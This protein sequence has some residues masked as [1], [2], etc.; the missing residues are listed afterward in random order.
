VFAIYG[1]QNAARLAFYGLY[2]LQHRGQQSAG[3]VT[4]GQGDGFAFKKGMGLVSEVFHEDDFSRLPGHIAC[5]HVGYASAGSYRDIQP[6]SIRYNDQFFTLTMTGG[7]LN[8]P[9]LRRRLEKEGSIFQTDSDSE[10]IMHLLARHMHQGL[11]QGLISALNLL[12]GAYCLLLMTNDSL[13]AARDP[14]GFRPLCLGRMEDAYILASETCAL[15]LMDAVY[16]REVEPGEILFVNRQGLRSLKPFTP[17]KHAHC[18]FEFV[19]FARPD[20]N[21]FGQ[22]VYL[23]RKRQGEILAEENRTV[24]A[25]FAMSFPDSGTYAALGYS[26]ARGIPFEMGII[27]NHYVGRTFIQPSPDIRDFQIK[28]KLN[29]VRELVRGQEVI[30]VDDSIVRGT[31]IKAR[32]QSLRRAGA[33]KIKA[34]IAS[35]PCRHACYY[36]VDFLGRG[37]LMAGSHTVEETMRLL[38]LDDLRYLSAGG[39]LRS[40]RAEKNADFCLAC[41][42]NNYPLPP[43]EERD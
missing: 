4:A 2:A 30:V 26:A 7:I 8:G 1:H 14:R 42:D 32:V 16:L 18:I 15:D 41:F 23:A 12:R 13:I 40:V 28:I 24:T 33:A 20:S 34:L 31:T 35:P 38:D 9:S 37:E 6:F 17:L 29:P 3:I 10:L 11:E 5:G 22:N 25:K 39:L 27:R 43:E 19:Y 21:V 36:G